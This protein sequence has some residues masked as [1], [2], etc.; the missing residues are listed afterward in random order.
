MSTDLEKLREA[1]AA[2]EGDPE[3]MRHNDPFPCD[4]ADALRAYDWMAIPRAALLGY[5][6]RDA[7]ISELKA[8][9]AKLEEQ[10][11]HFAGQCVDRDE[12]IHELGKRV[13][14]AESGNLDADLSYA[15][16][17]NEQLRDELAAME[18]PWKNAEFAC[19]IIGEIL[20][21]GGHPNIKD[22]LERIRDSNSQLRYGTWALAEGL[23]ETQAE[24]ARLREAL[25]KIHHY[26][27]ANN[28]IS[29][30]GW[31]GGVERMAEEALAEL[32]AE[33]P[34]VLSFRDTVLAAEAREK[35]NTLAPDEECG[36]C[37]F[38]RKHPEAWRP[39]CAHGHLTGCPQQ[40]EDPRPALAFTD[41]EKQQFIQ[42][43]TE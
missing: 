27:S 39:A 18:A 19:P 3:A 42:E 36:P 33:A 34:R 5:R 26:A 28:Q 16:S 17:V 43:E 8:E 10:V 21:S 6:C 1:L 2:Y 24:N 30:E 35:A 15:R 32:A 7:E 14:M 31:L 22:S 11:K 13:A 40:D 41:E 29:Y 12:E 38:H 9:N 4:V 20:A 25:E 37:R 23:N